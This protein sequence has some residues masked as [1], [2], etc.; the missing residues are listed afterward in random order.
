[1]RQR[2]PPAAVPPPFPTDEF[3]LPSHLA[4]LA[5]SREV[6]EGGQRPRELPVGVWP[7]LPPSPSRHLGLRAALQFRP[8]LLGLR[9][10]AARPR[11][12]ARVRRGSLF[13][14]HDALHARPRRRPARG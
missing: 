1:L 10:E 9:H 4:L 3:L 13:Q 14:R 2:L 6:E 8:A 5:V 11:R 12:G 7:S